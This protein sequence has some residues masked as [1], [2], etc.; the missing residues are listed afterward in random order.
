LAPV[1][2]AD[3]PLRSIT[4]LHSTLSG[5]AD[6]LRRCIAPAN[7]ATIAKVAMTETAQGPGA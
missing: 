6:G 1:M 4:R 5:N 2:M 7:P 3:L